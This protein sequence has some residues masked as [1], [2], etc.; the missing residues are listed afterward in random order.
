MG[1]VRTAYQLAGKFDVLADEGSPTKDIV[2]TFYGIFQFA[3][4]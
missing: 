2:A 3:I 4:L 1:L